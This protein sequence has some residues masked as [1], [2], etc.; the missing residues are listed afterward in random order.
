MQPHKYIYKHKAKLTEKEQALRSVCLLF[1]RYHF[2]GWALLKGRIQWPGTEELN[3]FAAYAVAQQNAINP[4]IKDIDT[5]LQAIADAGGGPTIVKAVKR[6]AAGHKYADLFLCNTANGGLSGTKSINAL[7]K[8][9]GMSI[10]T[11][12]RLECDY[13]GEVARAIRQARRD[14]AVTNASQNV[15]KTPVL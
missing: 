1:L 8:E 13:M 5:F 7:A 2:M 10:R 15:C 14:K 9:Y 3:D 12:R 6:Y 4:S 11:M